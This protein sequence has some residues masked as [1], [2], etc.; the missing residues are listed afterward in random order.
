MKT[1]NIS[2]LESITSK[3]VLGVDLNYVFNII[4]NGI[5]L[6]KG[7]DDNETKQNLYKLKKEGKLP[8]MAFSVFCE[9]GH[10]KT[11]IKEYTHLFC[12]DID[13][14]KSEEEAIRIKNLISSDSRV[15]LCFISPSQKGVKFILKLKLLPRPENILSNKNDENRF[16]QLDNYHKAWFTIIS[17]EIKEKYN[18]E[19]DTQCS[20]VNRLCYISYDPQAYFNPNAKEYEFEGKFKDIFPIYLNL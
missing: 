10:S 11:K 3:K 14:L 20:N 2:L 15:V 4:K 17:N 18:I 13:N 7:R 6:Y 5:S 1:V 16:K 19:L 8:V 12:G 9:G